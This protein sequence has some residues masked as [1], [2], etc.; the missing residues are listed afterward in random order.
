MDAIHLAT[1]IH[2]CG[3]CKMGPSPADGNV[4]N[5]YGRVHGVTGLRVA[6]TSIFPSPR[7][8]APPPP[9]S[10]PASGSPISSAPAPTEQPLPAPA[11]GTS[12]TA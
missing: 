1:A 12:A 8:A 3:T 9:R 5:Q 11:R 2:A 7:A 6:D 4:V 10:W